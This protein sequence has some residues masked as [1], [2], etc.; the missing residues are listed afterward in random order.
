MVLLGTI[1][2]YAGHVLWKSVGWTARDHTIG[3]VISKTYF[4][5]W[6]EEISQKPKFG[7]L[8][9]STTQYTIAET[10]TD[11]LYALSRGNTTALV[12]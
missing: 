6:E 8:W 3:M 5:P 2:R 10:A 1:R 4:F 11:M 9:H 7:I 12:A